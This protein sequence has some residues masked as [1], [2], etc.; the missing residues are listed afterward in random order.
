MAFALT[1]ASVGAVVG[2]RVHGRMA[3]GCRWLKRRGCFAFPAFPGPPQA[4]AAPS[5]T[6]HA[7]RALPP[8]RH[9]AGASRTERTSSPSRLARVT[10]AGEGL[11]TDDQLP[12]TAA[13]QPPPASPTA[14][15]GGPSWLREEDVDD[16]DGHD[17][18]N[19]LHG[20]R[21]WGA[22]AQQAGAAGRTPQQLQSS[23]Q[24]AL[25]EEAEQ[26]AQRKTVLAA[27]RVRACVHALGLGSGCG[28]LR[29]GD[30]LSR[31]SFSLLLYLLMACRRKPRRGLRRW[32]RG[33]CGRRCLAAGPTAP[34]PCH[35][36]VSPHA[37]ALGQPL[38]SYTKQ[39]VEAQQ[40]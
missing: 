7:P 22:A 9:T 28:A 1:D 21:A 3:R 34:P 33:S 38:A 14:G 32:S 16:E 26:A 39:Q 12:P 35:P 19:P 24:R 29:C 40:P 2:R 37:R 30:P 11:L 10:G 5:L 4:G 18:V 36:T 31:T 25:A 15:G 13:G 20:A 17:G 23:V 6:T 8:S 27:Q